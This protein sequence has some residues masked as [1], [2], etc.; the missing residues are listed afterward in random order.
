[1]LAATV[2]KLPVLGVVAPMLP[3]SA[4]PVEFSVVA[5]TAAGVVCP[6]G[7]LSIVP[8]VTATL[9]AFCVAIVPRPR[10]VLAPAAVPEPVP[11]LAIPTGVVAVSVVKAPAA[12]VVCP[13]GEL[14]IVFPVTVTPL[15]V[16]L[17]TCKLTTFGFG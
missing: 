6:I 17:V 5:V 10:F 15:S 3:F 1:M 7:V 14:L 11:P 9:F 2:V 8:P 13:I 12:G 16:P 4:P